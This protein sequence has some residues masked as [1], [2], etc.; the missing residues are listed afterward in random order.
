MS[1][2]VV[3]FGRSTRRRQAVRVEVIASSGAELAL[4]LAAVLH[5]ADFELDDDRAATLRAAA[6]EELLEDALAVAHGEPKIIMIVPALVA[7][8]DPPADADGLLRELA[9]GPPDALWRVVVEHLSRDWGVVDLALVDRAADGAPGALEELRTLAVE[10]D[11]DECALG[12]L[13]TPP[14]EL[15]DGMLDVLTRWRDRAFADLEEDALGPMRRS[16]A[17]TGELAEDVTLDE[18]VVTVTNGIEWAE[19]PGLD[20]ALLLPSFAFRPWV[21]TTEIDRTRVIVYPVADEHLR[22]QS[23]APPPRLVRLFKALAD[24]GRLRLLRRMQSGPISL[25]D[26][27]EELDVSKPTAH[28]HLATLRQAGLVVVR[29]EGRATTY[30]LRQDPGEAT[31]E[32]L[33]SYL[34]P[35]D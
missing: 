34:G 18:L 11:C 2:H 10:G 28:H 23:A 16:A 19:D 17:A 1:A 33:V 27:A 9:E 29:D 22:L 30:A 35:Q 6:G 12:V 20:R 24:E 4:S 5:E 14:H 31:H 15:R 21:V 25:S 3:D 7:R 8:L 13:D 32:A 26:A